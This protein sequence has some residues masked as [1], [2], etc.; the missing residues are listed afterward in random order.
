V[1]DLRRP[2]SEQA[3]R[4]LVDRH[5]AGQSKLLRE[6]FY[7]SLLSAFTIDEVRGQLDTAGLSFLT[8]EPVPDRFFDVVGRMR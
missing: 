7:R 1:R 3:A 4:D 8:I 5:A 6:E 2:E